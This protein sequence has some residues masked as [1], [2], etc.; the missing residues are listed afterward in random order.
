MMK[1]REERGHS[2]STND[3]I[4]SRTV[5]GN[6]CRSENVR[7]RE[8]DLP[9]E[10]RDAMEKSEKNRKNIGISDTEEQ[11]SSGEVRCCDT[12]QE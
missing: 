8:R 7:S 6:K 5:C 10:N 9:E 2:T 1:M 11:N 12:R 4:T 3:C